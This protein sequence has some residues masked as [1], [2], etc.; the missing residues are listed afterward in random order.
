MAGD[1][2]LYEKPVLT[3]HQRL[4][5][6]YVVTRGGL[7]FDHDRD[8]WAIEL[9]FQLGRL[10]FFFGNH[11]FDGT[12]LGTQIRQRERDWTRAIDNGLRAR[13]LARLDESYEQF[14]D[15]VSGVFIRIGDER[16]KALALIGIA[17][18]RLATVEDGRDDTNAQLFASARALLGQISPYHLPDPDDLLAELVAAGVESTADVANVLA[19]RQTGGRQTEGLTF[20]YDRDLWAVDLG[21]SLGGLELAFR[22]RNFEGTELGEHMRASEQ[23]LTSKLDAVLMAR[24][25]GNLRTDYADF[26]E[27]ASDVLFRLRDERLKALALIGVCVSRLGIAFGVEGDARES[28]MTHAR[29]SLNGVGAFH[30]PDRDELFASLVSA[31]ADTAANAGVVLASRSDS[32]SPSARSAEVP[33]GPTHASIGAT[34]FISYARQDGDAALRLANDLRRAGVGVWID[35]DSLRPGQRWRPAIS[36]AIENCQY[37]IAVLSSRSVNHRGYVQAELREALDV[38]RQVPDS[39]TFVIPVRL[40][41]AKITNRDLRELNWVDLFPDWTRGLQQLVAGLGAGSDDAVSALVLGMTPELLNTRLN[42]GWQLGRYEIVQGSEFDEARAA[43]PEVREEIEALLS[44]VD[45]ECSLEGA[46]AR[47]TIRRI[48][49]RA[50]SRDVREHGAILIGLA[51]FRVQLVG[52][53]SDPANDEELKR[54]VFS[55]LLEV[56]PTVAPNKH[57]LF[58]EIMKA[59]PT[60]IVGLAELLRG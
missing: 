19:E 4:C 44:A 18:S 38:L 49:L 54:L 5:S 52:N 12:E 1:V 53:S 16:L 21:S 59:R 42:L 2:P 22:N 26:G 9:G 31:H 11:N 25:F 43:E 47:Q 40:D 35:R 14:G 32:S 48:L 15:L 36:D 24:G 23:H 13:G 57:A 8:S 56:D 7:S 27:L 20:D 45:L 58:D 10:E 60:T 6:D 34:V 3:R 30:L 29:E 33:S 50:Q 39:E 37:F 55:A 41:D 28:L 17:A 51:A 46:A